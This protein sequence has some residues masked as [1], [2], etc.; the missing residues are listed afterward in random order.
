MSKKILVV[1]D[2]PDIIE[3][4]RSRLEEEKYTV[5]CANNGENGVQMAQQEKPDLII[6]D[7]MM[8][9]M[10]GGEAVKLLM[11]HEST[12]HIPVI[13]L[14]VLTSDMPVQMEDRKINIDGRFFPT[15]A[16]PFQP[17]QLLSTIR[18]LIGDE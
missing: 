15:I 16:K 9:K 4:I 12:R 17:V 8:P 1:D 5:V 2:N 7:V 11:E 6:M 14:T 10:Q 13:F 18:E 3:V